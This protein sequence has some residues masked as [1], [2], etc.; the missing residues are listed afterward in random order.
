MTIRIQSDPDKIVWTASMMGRMG[1]GRPKNFSPEERA[2]RRAAMHAI[3]ERRR[4]RLAKE[5]GEL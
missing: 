1:K 3:N 5:R 2:K 4:I